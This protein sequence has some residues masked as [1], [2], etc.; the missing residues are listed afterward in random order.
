LNTQDATVQTKLR[1]N[2]EQLKLAS[3]ICVSHSAGFGQSTVFVNPERL[4]FSACF[5]A[6]PSQFVLNSVLFP[7]KGGVRTAKKGKGKDKR[8]RFFEY[9]GTDKTT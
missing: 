1:R 7:S 6:V 2:R 4:C 3:N 8:I 5:V 9:Y